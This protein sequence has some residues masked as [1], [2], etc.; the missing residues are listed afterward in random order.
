M[1]Y[2]GST[3]F[4]NETL[5]ENMNYRVRKNIP[6]VLYGTSIKINAKYPIGCL[7]FIIEMNNENNNIEGIGLIRNNLVLDKHKIYSN[8]DYNR[9]I[10]SGDYWISGEKL[11]EY[12]NELFDMLINMLFKGKSHL[13][14][15]SGISIL[16]KKLYENWKYD[17]N[18]IKKR[19]R[20]LFVNTYKSN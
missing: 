4:N 5:D 14:R 18:D 8:G 13:K 6:G 19:I 10:Y 15:Q 11:K 17:E 1:Y 7:I 16:T 3:R 20:D 2:I 12:N 9:Y